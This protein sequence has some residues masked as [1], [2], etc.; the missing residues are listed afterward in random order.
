[1][2]GASSMKEVVHHDTMLL[3][4]DSTDAWKTGGPVTKI[5]DKPYPFDRS[6]H[7]PNEKDVRK[8]YQ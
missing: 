1:M 2:V 4:S 3:L 6:Q 7:R 5:T 8:M